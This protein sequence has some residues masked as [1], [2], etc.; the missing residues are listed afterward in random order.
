MQSIK[1]IA[2]L[3][4]DGREGLVLFF[5]VGEHQFGVRLTEVVRIDEITAD[6]RC[7]L[8]DSMIELD[9][10]D[11]QKFFNATLRNKTGTRVLIVFGT[12][13]EIFGMTADEV[14]QII[15]AQETPELKWPPQ[16][17]GNLEKIY[18]GF[19]RR[20]EKLVPAI[21]PLAIKEEALREAC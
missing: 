16:L 18:S 9:T 14:D 15:A 20:G 21:N 10:I 2:E 13:E 3:P 19:F 12:D 7:E 1:D 4:I 11:L 6:G 17:D 5:N 8:L